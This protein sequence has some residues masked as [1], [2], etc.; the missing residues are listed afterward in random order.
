[1]FAAAL[2]VSIPL[3]AQAPSADWRTATTPHFRVHYPLQYEAWSLRAASR[4]ESIREAVIREVGFAPPQ[5]IDV[6]VGNPLAEPNG[7]A[8][9]LLDAPRMVFYAEPPDAD[10]QIGEYGEWSEL[11][12]VHE[13]AHVVHMT[14]RS[15]NPLQRAV[16]SLLLPVGPIALSS[17]RWVLEGYATVIEGRLTG[18]GRP[19]SAMRAAILRKWAREGRLPSYAQLS[20]DRRFLGMSMAYLTG[21]AFL[22]WLELRGGAGSL[23]KLWARMTARER[24]SFD[25]AF[26]GVFADTP[27]RLYGLFSAELT[28]SSVYISRQSTFYEGALWQEPRSGSGDPVVSPNGREIALVVRSRLLPPR[29]VVLATDEATAEETR[30]S[31]RIARTMERDPEDVPPLLT[32]PVKRNP[33]YQTVLPNGGAIDTPRWM[34]DGSSILFTRKSTDRHG[35]LHN[36]LALWQLRSGRIIA[37]TREAD[38]SDADVAPD[39][40]TAIAVRSRYGMSQL[41]S[42]DLATGEVS[43]LTPPSIDRVHNRPRISSDGKRLAYV[44]HDGGRWKV[45]VRDLITS[46]E[47]ELGTGEMTA[48]S[49]EWARDREGDLIASAASAGFID[50]VR[51]RP[52][53]A[54]MPLTRTLGAAVSPAP[55]PDGRLFFMSLEPDGFIVRVLPPSAEPLGPRPVFT[56]ELVPAVPPAPAPRQEFSASEV[57]SETYGIGRQEMAFIAGEQLSPHAK[58]LEIGA[59][60]GDIVG[61]LSAIALASFGDGDGVSGGALAAAWRGWPVHVHAHAYGAQQRDLSMRGAELRGLYEVRGPL[62]LWSVNAGV[63]RGELEHAP[64]DIA[65]VSGSLRGW[66]LSGTRRVIGDVDLLHSRGDVEI[67]RGSGMLTMHFGTVRAAARLTLGRTM[68]GTTLAVGGT[69][70]SIVPDAAFFDRVYDSSLP[71]ASLT[72]ERYDGRRYELRPTSLPVTLFWQQHRLWLVEDGARRRMRTAGLEATFGSEAQPL[73]Q[74]PGFAVTAGVARL[75]DEPLR[76]DTTLWL[77]LRWRP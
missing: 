3:L 56:A 13:I 57:R 69:Q 59:R 37:I 11:L 62:S 36:D 41:V 68:E 12:S 45:M 43:Q 16:E 77:V 21:S 58:A 74:L 10:E 1:M 61:R 31:Q 29:L 7:L 24:R 19:S 49:V 14:R 64:R 67:L 4:L 6:I 66:R 60:S 75:L 8:F 25:E 44:L 20:S 23:R 54:P 2:L 33:L 55:S 76:D 72:G 35:D 51:L 30:L 53:A 26:E 48:A 65:F 18:T 42:V 46:N 15:R 27:Q 38:I 40:R 63:H 39:G 50:L 34:P 28:A 70:S 17:P 22:E 5:V 52:G 71:L 47:I 32:R 73:L 9:P